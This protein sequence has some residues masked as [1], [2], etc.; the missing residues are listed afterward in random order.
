MCRQS[1]Q[2][3]TLHP[4]III[5]IGQPFLGGMDRCVMSQRFVFLVR[6]LYPRHGLT[7]RRRWRAGNRSEGK[8]CL[9]GGAT[10]RSN[11]YNS[12]QLVPGLWL[13]M[14]GSCS[15]KDPRPSVVRVGL[16]R[17]CDRIR[18]SRRV[19]L[20]RLSLMLEVPGRHER[21]RKIMLCGGLSGTDLCLQKKGV[22]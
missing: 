11:V 3:F 2:L 21:E 16:K 1:P 8:S 6:V 14:P 4:R 20:V 12:L 18:C 13:F 10:V 19:P 22:D 15:L 7:N 9:C 17:A 5:S